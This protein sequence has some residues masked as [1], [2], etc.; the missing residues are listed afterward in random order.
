MSRN[1]TARLKGM[2]G[3]Q[4]VRASVSRLYRM[5]GQHKQHG[6][7]LSTIHIVVHYQNATGNR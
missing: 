1:I 5:P 4:G 2:G 7:C 6:E 3:L